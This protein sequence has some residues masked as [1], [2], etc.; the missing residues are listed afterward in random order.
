M[1]TILPYLIAV[2]FVCTQ[3]QKDKPGTTPEEQ[4]DYFSCSVNGQ[5]WEAY[6][7]NS[8]FQNT[9]KIYA[10]LHNDNL[11]LTATKE[12]PYGYEYIY[13]SILDVSGIK[14]YTPFY[15]TDE[16][17]GYKNNQADCDLYYLTP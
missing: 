16:T 11:V 2:L 6:K 5:Y 14:E 12:L 13:V 3:C 10:Q 1:H 7:S 17:K 8:G 9:P 15:N 4:G